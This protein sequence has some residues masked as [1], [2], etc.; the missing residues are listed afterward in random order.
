MG[1]WKDWARSVVKGVILEVAPE[2]D[3]LARNLT[4]KAG[5]A[6]EQASRALRAAEA[7]VTEVRELRRQMAAAQALDIGFK[8]N[9]KVVILTR[10]NDRDIVKFID[11]KPEMTATE[12]KDL[13]ERLKHDFGLGDPVWVDKPAGMDDVF[14]GVTPLRKKAKVSG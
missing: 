8:E 7:A 3:G 13:V 1:F 2:L 4:S 5:E 9:G 10:I 12:Y 14:V 11:I 6:M